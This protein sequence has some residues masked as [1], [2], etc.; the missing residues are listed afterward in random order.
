MGQAWWVLS[1][2]SFSPGCVGGPKGSPGLPGPPGPP[3]NVPSAPPVPGPLDGTDSSTPNPGSQLRPLLGRNLW[4][5][6][7][8]APWLN[9]RLLL[10]RTHPGVALGGH[11]ESHP[12]GLGCCSGAVSHPFLWLGVFCCPGDKGPRGTPG[13]SGVDGPPG[14]KGFPGDPGREGFPGPP[15]ES[16]WEGRAGSSGI[17]QV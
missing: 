4:G 7:Q 8:A 16:G 11:R 1:P 13:F 5:S 10:R 6:H 3:G 12:V 9:G 15:G 2:S 17:F 14:L